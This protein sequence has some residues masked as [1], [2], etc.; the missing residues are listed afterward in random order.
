[1]KKKIVTLGLLVVVIC[2]ATLVAEKRIIP[3]SG[4]NPEPYCCCRCQGRLRDDLPLFDSGAVADDFTP[5]FYQSSEF[6]IGRVAV[7][8]ILPES[9]GRID[10]STEDWTEDERA[11]VRSEIAAAL[12]WWTAREPKAHLTFICDDG[13]IAPITMSYE[14]ITHGLND[15]EL[16]I[17][18]VMEKKGYRGS[19]YF[20]QVRCYNS[21]LRDAYD[22]DWSFIIFVVDS[23][24]DGDDMFADGRFAYAY[25]GGPFTVVTYGNNGYG[26][27]DLDAVIAHEIGHIFLALDQY[28]YAYQPCESTSGYLDVENQNSRYGECLLDEPSIMRGGTQ[29]YYEG[30]VDEYARGQV[31]WRDSDSDGIL[32]PVDTSLSFT[33]KRVILAEESDDVLLYTGKVSDTPFPSPH[34]ADLTIN[35][36]AAIQYRLDGGKWEDAETDGSLD[37]HTEAFTV[38]LEVPI[39][40]THILSLRAANSASVEKSIELF[41]NSS[42][43]GSCHIY[44][45]LVLLTASGF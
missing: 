34:R 9:D 6:M 18:E 39:S 29:P 31:G 16:W 33:C 20:E 11:L 44:L 15:Q 17:A 23:S 13:T 14:P 37:S 35:T 43:P 40:E 12:E 7:G 36:I 45:P 42:A 22:A 27:Q 21:D 19:S 41:T 38:T 28:H 5:G 3:S 4:D 8:I 10:P 24:E 25:L 32:D 2:C 1:M 26:S 30:A